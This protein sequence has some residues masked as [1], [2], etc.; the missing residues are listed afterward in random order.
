MN[1]H[2]YTFIYLLMYFY[3]YGDL[4][5]MYCVCILY[6]YVRIH[7]FARIFARKVA[8]RV[9]TYIYV[10][11]LIYVQNTSHIQIIYIPY[12]YK[13]IQYTYN[14][15]RNSFFVYVYWC[16]YMHVCVVYWRIFDYIRT[17]TKKYVRSRYMHVYVR[18]HKY[19]HVCHILATRT[20]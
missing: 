2:S 15:F 5:C 20:G 18:I 7:V 16:Q 14:F 8:G 1:I 11:I 10:H 4:Y 6:V 9:D 17:V 3:V 13:Y 19:M 12:T